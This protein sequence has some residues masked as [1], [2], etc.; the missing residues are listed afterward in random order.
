M[1]F[2]QHAAITK[3]STGN[4]IY[5]GLANKPNSNFMYDTASQYLKVTSKFATVLCFKRI[6]TFNKILL[7]SYTT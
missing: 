2:R 6:I 1:K 3:C 4:F 7:F 5:A